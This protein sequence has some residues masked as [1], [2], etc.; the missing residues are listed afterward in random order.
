MNTLPY[1]SRLKIEIG[2]VV[3]GIL[4]CTI[5]MCFYAALAGGY[6]NDLHMWLE[7]VSTALAF[8]FADVMGSMAYRGMGADFEDHPP[9]KTDAKYV[10]AYVFALLVVASLFV[11]YGMY[12][13][14]AS[15]AK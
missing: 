15:F 10:M 14:V 1:S 7:V 12:A 5:Q 6:I 9:T 8:L 3:F 2:D 13:F 4:V 11:N